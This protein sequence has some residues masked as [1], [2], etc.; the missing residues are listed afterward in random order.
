E[1]MDV[2]WLQEATPE[3]RVR[4]LFLINN[5]DPLECGEGFREECKNDASTAQAAAKLSLKKNTM[6]DI[7]NEL[8]KRI[9]AILS[10]EIK[11]VPHGT[12]CGEYEIN[13]D[14][15]DFLVF[16]SAC[17][18]LKIQV[19]STDTERFTVL[20]Q[21]FNFSEKEL[22]TLLPLDAEKL[23]YIDVA[24]SLDAETI[25]SVWEEIQDNEEIFDPA[26]TITKPQ[27]VALKEALFLMI[28]RQ[29]QI[30]VKINRVYTGKLVNILKKCNVNNA[31]IDQFRCYPQTANA[32]VPSGF[33]TIFS[34]LENRKGAEVEI[35]KISGTFESL[36]F[37]VHDK[38]DPKLDDI[39]HMKAELSKPKYMF[40]SSLVCWFIS[41]GDSQ[42]VQ[43]KDGEINRS[44]LLQKFSNLKNFNKKPKI[45]FMASCLGD[46]HVTLKIGN[47]FFVAADA[48]SGGFLNIP[49][50]IRDITA[51]H[52]EM[53]RLV[54]YSTLDW[55]YAYRSEEEGSIYVDR[56]C[57]LLKQ[58][59]N[60]GRNIT[61]VLE[62]TAEELHQILFSEE[63]IS[64]LH[65]KQGCKYESTLQKTFKVPCVNEKL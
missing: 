48:K 34:V 35:N 10:S 60:R 9:S 25:W 61:E 39:E 64:D 4:L 6:E 16:D 14:E 28:V 3:A 15:I 2:S 29:L 19:P 63:N 58:E 20:Y 45:V 1:N 50:S 49:D 22:N 53:D 33:C 12:P 54:A 62:E 27:S 36:N 21:K 30:K 7:D 52:S 59:E 51:V 11:P 44:E 31:I 38:I 24:Q 26:I 47:G 46:K 23:R 13:K 55:H 8:K 32:L 42:K 37:V 56:V 5:G 65:L 40:Y 57:N 43:L 41:H 17:K 18:Y